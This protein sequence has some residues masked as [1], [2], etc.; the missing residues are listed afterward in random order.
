MSNALSLLL[1][2]GWLVSVSPTGV[3]LTWNICSY[4]HSSSSPSAWLRPGPNFTPP[5]PMQCDVFQWGSS[6]CSNVLIV[7]QVIVLRIS[8][9]IISTGARVVERAAGVLLGLSP[10]QHLHL[11]HHTARQ[12]LGQLHPRYT[13]GLGGRDNVALAMLVRYRNLPPSIYGQHCSSKI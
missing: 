10:L 5:S 11:L 8:L 9:P 4:S 2:P 3:G 1:T 12:P 6:S 13:V 7:I